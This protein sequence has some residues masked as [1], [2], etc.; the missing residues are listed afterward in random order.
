M[1]TVGK[2]WNLG[3]ICCFVVLLAGC[4]SPPPEGPTYADARVEIEALE[5]ELAEIRHEAKFNHAKATRLETEAAQWKQEASE[6]QLK[7]SRLTDQVES[8][9]R[10]LEELEQE[11]TL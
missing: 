3:I 1:S 6:W 5:A 8:L 7:S 10:R 4:G 9:S 11:E 2:S